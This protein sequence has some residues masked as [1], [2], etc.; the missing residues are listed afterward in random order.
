MLTVQAQDAA[1]GGSPLMAS[2][3]AR[4]L[5]DFVKPAIQ[6]VDMLVFTRQLHTLLKSGV[7]IL[8][9]LAGLD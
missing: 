4:A 3:P 1:G 2:Q 6:P 8:R 5:D 9:A 7:P